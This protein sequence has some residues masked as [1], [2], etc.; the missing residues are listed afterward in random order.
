MVPALPWERIPEKGFRR[1]IIPATEC[2][3]KSFASA[4]VKPGNDN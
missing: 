2:G 3:K 1:G 4:A